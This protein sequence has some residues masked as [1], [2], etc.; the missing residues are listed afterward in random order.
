L[1]EGRAGG[2]GWRESAAPAAVA[3]ARAAARRTHLRAVLLGGHEARAELRRLRAL[4]ADDRVALVELGGQ[5]RV[6]ARAVVR[7]QRVVAAAVA[8]AVAAQARRVR[9]RRVRGG[10]RVLKGA[11]RQRRVVRHARA[12][13][14]GRAA[15]RARRRQAAGVAAGRRPRRRRL[16]RVRASCRG[17]GLLRAQQTVK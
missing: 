14:A 17:V 12:R 15:A 11:V 6:A 4:E 7:R 8:A 5:P 10:V 3:A 2:C 9:V 1:K 16:R 13:R